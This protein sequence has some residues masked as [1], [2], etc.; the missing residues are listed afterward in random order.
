MEMKRLSTTTESKSTFTLEE[1][2]AIASLVALAV[3]GFTAIGFTYEFDLLSTSVVLF[4]VVLDAIYWLSVL[5]YVR[6]IEW[7]YTVGI[8]A[9]VLG[10]IAM[11]PFGDGWNL[12]AFVYPVLDL[13][14][15]MA[16]VT[17]VVGLYFS[18]KLYKN[19]HS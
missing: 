13:S 8:I 15:F 3:W 5:L 18:Y 12:F 4:F 11:I 14:A 17:L 10:I 1:T 6:R 2:G 19:V 9:I 16:L 7:G